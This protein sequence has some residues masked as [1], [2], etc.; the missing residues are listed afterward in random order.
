MY[1]GSH[2]I[3]LASF[4]SQTMSYFGFSTHVRASNT[5]GTSFFCNFELVVPLFFVCTRNETH[6]VSLSL[7]SSVDFLCLVLS[8]CCLHFHYFLVSYSSLF[9][10]V[11]GSVNYCNY[12]KPNYGSQPLIVGCP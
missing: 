8:N 1:S 6:V 9:L 5:W 2:N 12:R 10:G 11:L 7:F 4:F 3:F